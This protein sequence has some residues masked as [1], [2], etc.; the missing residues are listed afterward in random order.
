MS[1]RVYGDRGNSSD[2]S[3]YQ[4]EYQPTPPD[5][6]E[7][8][9]PEYRNVDR[10]VDES[11]FLVETYLAGRGDTMRAKEQFLAYARGFSPEE[12]TRVEI[13]LNQEFERAYDRNVKMKILELKAGIA[14]GMRDAYQQPPQRPYRDPYVTGYE[15]TYREDRYAPRDPYA[16]SD[17]HGGHESRE[18]YD[19]LPFRVVGGKDGSYQLAQAYPTQVGGGRWEIRLV[20]AKSV[21]SG[22]ISMQREHTI[23]VDNIRGAGVANVSLDGGGMFQLP[24]GDR[25]R[26]GERRLLQ[27]YGVEVEIEMR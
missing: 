18:R 24:T 12:R 9:Q 20:F 25:R 27:A 15:R 21:S 17:R 8:Y 19:E 22:W 10:V 6:R 2:R 13:Y 26:S 7:Q 4:P 3:Q 16:R 23:I 11:R 14:N 5:P 1:D